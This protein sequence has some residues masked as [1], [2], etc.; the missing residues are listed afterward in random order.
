MIQSSK[1]EMSYNL[2][3]FPKQKIQNGHSCSIWF[4]ST[5]TLLMQYNFNSGLFENNKFLFQIIKNIEK[6]MNIDDKEITVD[7]KK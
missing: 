3:K 4:I 2:V 5:L 6:I 1:K 7:F